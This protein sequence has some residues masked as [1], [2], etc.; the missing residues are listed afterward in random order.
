MK[1]LFRASAAVFMISLPGTALARQCADGS[2]RPVC[3]SGLN[4]PKRPNRPTIIPVEKDYAS[5]VAAYRND[6]SAYLSDIKNE[7]ASGAITQAQYLQKLNAYNKAI[8]PPIV[9]MPHK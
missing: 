5:N 8:R 6:L 4:G 7:R 3:P 1:M 2:Y 9:T